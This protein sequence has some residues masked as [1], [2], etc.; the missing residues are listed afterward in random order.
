MQ[1][2]QSVQTWIGGVRG[3][4][5]RAGLLPNRSS[6]RSCTRGMIHNKFQLI[7]PRLSPDEYSLTVQNRDLSTIHFQFQTYIYAQVPGTAGWSEAMWYAVFHMT[8]TMGIEPHIFRSW[9]LHFSC[10][11]KYHKIILH[12]CMTSSFSIRQ[13]SIHSVRF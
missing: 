4:W 13:N 7:R 1:M 11:A 8:G 3:T 2:Q 9:V 5:V 10:L 12:V 6:D